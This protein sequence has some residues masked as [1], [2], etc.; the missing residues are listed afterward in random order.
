MQARGACLVNAARRMA[1]RAHSS[2]PVVHSVG[3]RARCVTHDALRVLHGPLCVTHA[4]HVRRSVVR[5]G[6]MVPRRRAIVLLSDAMVRLRRVHA[7]RDRVHVRRCLVLERHG[8]PARPTSGAGARASN[9]T[10]RHDHVYAR[11]CN[12]D[13][14]PSP[15]N[16]AQSPVSGAHSTAQ[17]MP[18]V[19]QRARCRL[20]GPCRG[21][22]ATGGAAKRRR[23]PS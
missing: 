14:P 4:T 1:D 12:G 2:P 10:Q 8:C 22:H 20:H 16:G 3:K 9:A 19:M 17:R 18:R 13:G 23:C 11:R 7:A 6:A 5:C 15:M 21:R